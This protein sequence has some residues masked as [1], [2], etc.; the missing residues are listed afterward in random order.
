MDNFTGKYNS[1]ALYMKYLIL[2]LLMFFHNPVTGLAQDAPSE[3]ELLQQAARDWL[4]LID[5]QEYAESWEQASDQLQTKI[6]KDNWS[7]VIQTVRKIFGNLTEREILSANF[8][9]TSPD[10]PRGK[11]AVIKFTVYF[12]NAKTAVET[13]NMYKKPQ[14]NWTVS[15]Y[16]IE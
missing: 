13:L 3:G 7:D 8:I 16:Y 4:Q 15:G 6:S 11:Y 9:A 2:I 5:D 10:A 12:E 1:K 14:G